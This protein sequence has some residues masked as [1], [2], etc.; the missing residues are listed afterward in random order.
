MCQQ[1]CGEQHVFICDKMLKTILC[2]PLIIY[3]N[4]YYICYQVVCSHSLHLE[5]GSSH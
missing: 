1:V 4:Q 2:K 3:V 5:V